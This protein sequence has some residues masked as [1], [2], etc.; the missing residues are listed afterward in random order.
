MWK[1]TDSQ[2]LVLKRGDAIAVNEVTDEVE[3]PHT[4]EVLGWVDDSPMP[5]EAFKHKT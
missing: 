5:T 1:I 2:H 3:F 4:E